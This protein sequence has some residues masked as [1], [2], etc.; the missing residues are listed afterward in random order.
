VG[1]TYRNWFYWPIVVS[2]INSLVHRCEGCQ[3]FARQKHVM[4]HQLRT[5]SISLPFSTWGLDLVGPFKKVKGG[6]T[7]IFI[8]VD[9]FIKWIKVKTTTSITVAKVAE[10]IMEIMYRFGVRNNIITDNESQFTAREF[11]DFC[12][13]SGIK[14]NYASVSHPKSNCQ[15]K[16]SNGM[17]L[18]GLKP[19][20]FDR[21]KPYVGKWVKELPLVL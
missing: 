2:D 14:I 13:D 11:K 20:I 4:P 8:A 12:T 7:H 16:R 18:Q 15:V 17:I 9:R 21:L 3:F 10:F 19:I 6:F 5:I 1:K